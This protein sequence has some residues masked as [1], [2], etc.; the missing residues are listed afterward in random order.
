MPPWP[1]HRSKKTTR[2]TPSA[3]AHHPLQQDKECFWRRKDQRNSQDMA[4]KDWLTQHG[5]RHTETLNF[6]KGPEWWSAACP[7]SSPF[8]EGTQIFTGKKAAYL[9]ADQI[10]WGQPNWYLMGETSRH[11]N[12]DQGTTTE[13]ISKPQAWHL[14]SPPTSWTAPPDS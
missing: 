9:L 6:D 10:P 12:K 2:A 7:K 11:Q 4:R 1:T 5:E 14:S 13:T 8:E 3:R